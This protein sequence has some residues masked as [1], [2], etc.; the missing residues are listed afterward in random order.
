[1]ARKGSDKYA[2]QM[3]EIKSTLSSH[4]ELLS[5]VQQEL[6]TMNN[7]LSINTEQLKVHIQASHANAENLRVTKEFFESRVRPLEDHATVVKGY[8]RLFI[9]LMGA[10]AF[11]YYIIRIVKEFIH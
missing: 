5:S 2:E 7:T 10:P 3:G 8:L 6:K 11:A 1:M 9:I 4:S